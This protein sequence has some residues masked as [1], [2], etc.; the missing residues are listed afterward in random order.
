MARSTLSKLVRQATRQTNQFSGAR[1]SLSFRSIHLV[2]T[3]IAANQ[4]LTSSASLDLLRNFTSS[5]YTYKGLSPETEDPQPKE[6]E[7]HDQIKVPTE[8]SNEEYHE[9]SEK[10][11]DHMVEKLEELQEA[12]EDVEVEYSAG[13]LTLTFPPIGTY[14]L[15]KQPPNKQIWLSSPISGPKRYDWVVKG[16]GQHQKE[17]G[18]QGDWVYLRDGSSLSDVLAKEVGV[19]V[20]VPMDLEA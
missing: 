6:V 11:M 4:R 20:T 15:N 3:T 9:L 2:R 17:G 18:G 8:I 14:V 7:D 12:R 19:D 16:E 1:S 5:P 13:V 10:Y